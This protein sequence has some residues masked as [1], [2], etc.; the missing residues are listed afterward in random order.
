MFSPD[1]TL[2]ATAGGDRTVRVWDAGTGTQLGAVPVH[3]KAGPPPVLAFSPDGRWLV[4]ALDS[5]PL[6]FVD[7]RRPEQRTTLELGG[8][9]GLEGAHP[10]ALAFDPTG[11]RLFV[12]T[13][14]GTIAILRRE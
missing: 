13:G 7:A 12:G 2:L 3:R 14:R 10:R 8:I 1:G 6:I 11:A 9:P 4:V 5:G